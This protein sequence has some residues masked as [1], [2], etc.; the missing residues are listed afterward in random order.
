MM[1]LYGKQYSSCYWQ[2][3]YDDDDDD[4]YDDDEDVYKDE[5]DDDAMFIQVQPNIAMF[6]P[7]KPHKKTEQFDHLK[8]IILN[9]W[10][11]Y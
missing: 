6:F 5:D 9:L 10:I 2:I 1:N 11:V 8:K 7:V 4:N 3:S